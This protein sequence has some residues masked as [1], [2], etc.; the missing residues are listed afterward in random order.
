METKKFDT[1][2]YV[3]WDGTKYISKN[4]EGPPDDTV[5]ALKLGF[6]LMAVNKQQK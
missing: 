5:V 3:V 4:I 1:L 6:R 2:Q